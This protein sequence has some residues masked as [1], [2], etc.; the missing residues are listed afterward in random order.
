MFTHV[1]FLLFFFYIFLLY[2]FLYSFTITYNDGDVDDDD[3][4]DVV[5]H[6][7]PNITFPLLWDFFDKTCIYVCA[8]R[9]YGGL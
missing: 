2:F 3:D 5:H 6:Q 1:L 8:Y 4:E 9:M 7:T